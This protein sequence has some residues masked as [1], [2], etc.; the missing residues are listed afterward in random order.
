MA[1]QDIVSVPGAQSEEALASAGPD[2]LQEMIKG[3]RAAD[4]GRRCRGPLQR[5]LRGGDPERVNSRNGYRLR[6]WD[7]LGRGDGAQGADAAQVADR[8]G[9]QGGRP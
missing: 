3:V 6:E 8:I 1:A 4:D 9:G 7:T 5:R 2:L